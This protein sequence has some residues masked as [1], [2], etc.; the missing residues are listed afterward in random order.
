MRSGSDDDRARPWLL[1]ESFG[2][3]AKF[4][5]GIEDARRQ[6]SNIDWAN[7]LSDQH[8]AVVLFFTGVG[9]MQ[10]L[11]RSARLQRLRQPDLAG[12]AV[13]IKLRGGQGAVGKPAA[14]N[15]DGL[16][17]LQP[18]FA[19]QPQAGVEKRVNSGQRE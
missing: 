9:Q 1:I 5:R 3:R 16:R 10:I 6:K 7:A 18:I 2:N 14:E 15:N 13:T 4:V 17:F 12:E 8:H 11:H 19:N